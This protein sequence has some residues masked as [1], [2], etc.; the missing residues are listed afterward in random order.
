M[1]TFAQGGGEMRQGGKGWGQ[2]WSNWVDESGDLTAQRFVQSRNR[3]L[4]IRRARRDLQGISTWIWGF[5]VMTHTHAHAHTQNS[6]DCLLPL[7]AWMAS[8]GSHLR[9]GRIPAPVSEHRQGL[10][11]P[12]RRLGQ[13][14]PFEPDTR[15]TC[16]SNPVSRRRRFPRCACTWL[17][18]VIAPGSVTR[19]TGSAMKRRH[20]WHCGDWQRGCGGSRLQPV[21]RKQIKTQRQTKLAS[22]HT[23]L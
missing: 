17:P 3:G 19:Q 12:H 11:P 8:E 7:G 4:R 9:S 13:A 22:G 18:V 15:E 1:I 14:P 2:L 21:M 10:L 23:H 20:R 5:C 16:W 6:P